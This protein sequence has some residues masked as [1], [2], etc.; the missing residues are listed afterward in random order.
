MRLGNSLRQPEKKIYMT[1]KIQ[2]DRLFKEVGE[3]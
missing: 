1:F 2:T 3:S